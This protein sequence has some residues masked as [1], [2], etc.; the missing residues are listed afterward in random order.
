MSA[1]VAVVTGGAGFIGAELVAQLVGDGFHVRAIDN[2]VNG[3]PENLREH[4][5]PHCELIEADI[6]DQTRMREALTGVDVVYHLACLGVRHSIHSPHENHAVNATGTLVLLD[7]CRSRGV[8]RFVYVSSSEVYGTARSVPMGED[9]PTLPETVYGSS[10]LAGECYARAFNRTYGYP[11]VM[12]RPF[13][14]FGPRCHHEGDSG[15]V[16]PKFMLRGMAGLP[17][18]VFGDGRQTR[19]FTYV[20]D[21]AQGILRAGLVDEAVGQTLNLGS[22]REIEIRALAKQV[23]KL[24]ELPEARIQF[25]DPRPGDVRR[26]YSEVSRAAK[27]LDFHTTVS[28]QEG[29]GRV[30]DWY[31][32]AGCSP[33]E[34]LESEMV[35]NWEPRQQ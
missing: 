24:L 30:R 9:H 2:L 11:T 20:S 13:N 12:V 1:R 32:D 17:M 3:K 14:T 26:L 4:L 35:R 21:T 10:K 5:G 16:I 31:R 6:R 34:L 19:D 33:A 27:V 25:E 8:P 28:M 29:L 18:V 23:A 7:Q 22:G 15:E